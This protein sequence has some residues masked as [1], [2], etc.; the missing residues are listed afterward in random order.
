MLVRQRARFRHSHSNYALPVHIVIVYCYTHLAIYQG[1]VLS[2]ILSYFDF[3]LYDICH[4]HSAS[5]LHA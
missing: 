4:S 2:K 3:T 1:L 5:L